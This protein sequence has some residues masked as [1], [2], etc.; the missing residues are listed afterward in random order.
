M[1]PISSYT[2]Y[3]CVLHSHEASL[4]PYSFEVKIIILIRQNEITVHKNNA[5]RDKTSTQILLQ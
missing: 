5:Q 4:L 3:I 1:L 2:E